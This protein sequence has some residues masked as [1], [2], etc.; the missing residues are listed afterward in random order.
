MLTRYSLMVGDKGTV[1]V[2]VFV[3]DIGLVESFQP[4]NETGPRVPFSDCSDFRMERIL[5]EVAKIRIA[6]NKFPC[7]VKAKELQLCDVVRFDGLFGHATNAWSE[8][9][10]YQTDTEIVYL[11]RPF[12]VNSEFGAIS[13]SSHGN[14]CQKV[15][16]SIGFEQIEISRQ[17]NIWYL[18]FRREGIPANLV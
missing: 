2:F 16:A 9:S 13:T 15:Y 11:L 4:E 17:S 1:P 12:V 7:L 5:E 18:L 14:A 6:E 10:V 8:A 3:N